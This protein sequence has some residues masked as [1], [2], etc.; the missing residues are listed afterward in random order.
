MD[1][2]VDNRLSTVPEFDIG[3]IS[4]LGRRV[5]KLINRLDND[6]QV[7]RTSLGGI[8][9]QNQRGNG[10]GSWM[11]GSSLGHSGFKNRRGQVEKLWINGP[12]KNTLLDLGDTTLRKD[13]GKQLRQGLAGHN[14][15]RRVKLVVVVKDDIGITVGVS[16]ATPILLLA[17]THGRR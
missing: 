15:K 3:R 5:R 6:V 13:F 16:D 2:T 14:N 12:V 1:R 8:R 10:V 9:V 17:I 7:G 4:Q 11:D